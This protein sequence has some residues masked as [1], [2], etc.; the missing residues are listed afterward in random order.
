[1]W[2]ASGLEIDSF[3]VGARLRDDYIVTVNNDPQA[4]F[5]HLARLKIKNG[6]VRE[7]E[8]RP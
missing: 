8:T 1:V 5:W 2:L 7:K 6:A 4:K 3:E